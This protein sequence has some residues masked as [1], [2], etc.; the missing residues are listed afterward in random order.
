MDSVVRLF[1]WTLLSFTTVYFTEFLISLIMLNGVII[2]VK[3]HIILK[4][5]NSGKWGLQT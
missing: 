5:V 4:S 2:V 1:S 3:L